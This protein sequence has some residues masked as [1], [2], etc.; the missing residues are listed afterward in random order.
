MTT[1]RFAFARQASLFVWLLPLAPA[2]LSMACGSSPAMIGVSA[3]SAGVDNGNA[4]SESTSGGSGS[5]H[6][7]STGSTPTAGST[8]ETAGST[9]DTGGST[10]ETGGASGAASTAG[11]PSTG[12]GAG[13]AAG[14]PST[15]GA[16]GVGGGTCVKDA[17]CG[18]G[19]ECLYKMADGC[20]AKG[21]CHKGPTG[22]VCASLTEYCG[23]LGQ[24]VGVPCYEP[25]GYSPAPVTSPK[26]SATCAAGP[27]P[28]CAGKSCG[29]QC[30]NGEFPAA[31]DLDG[32]CTPLFT[33]AQCP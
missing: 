22:A 15:A 27:D 29:A 21:S 1:T 30:D 2:A 19:N 23:C 11:S 12:G 31:C 33:A 18:T 4:G 17:D 26:S 25:T 5:G 14:S 28:R 13:G 6:A 32:N 10:G 20:T 16:G 24:T 9:G 7:G 8:G 3:G